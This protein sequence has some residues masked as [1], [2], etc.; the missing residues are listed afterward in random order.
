MAIWLICLSGFFNSISR[1]QLVLYRASGNALHDNIRQGFRLGVLAVLAV[2]GRSIGFHG[3]LL[4]LVLAELIGVIYMFSAM[5]SV[6]SFFD[7]EKANP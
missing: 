7:P 6:L 1:L 2:F 4:G 5:T 3:V